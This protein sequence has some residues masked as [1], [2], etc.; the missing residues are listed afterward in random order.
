MPITARSGRETNEEA[1]FM[2]VLIDEQQSSV[3]N[4]VAVEISFHDQEVV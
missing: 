1:H 4:P 3:L 2:I